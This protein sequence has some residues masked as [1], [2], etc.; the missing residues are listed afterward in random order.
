MDSN[1]CIHPRER[2]KFQNFIHS[3]GF[4]MSYDL[5]IFN[6][7][8]AAPEESFQPLHC[9]LAW[10]MLSE[11]LAHE[12]VVSDADELVWFLPTRTVNIYIGHEDETIQSMGVSMVWGDRSQED[13][14][15]SVLPN[16]TPELAQ[17]QKADLTKIFI[18]LHSLAEKLHAQLYDPQR[19][20]FLKRE[21]IAAMVEGFD[22]DAAV[23][24][25]MDYDQTEDVYLQT[26]DEE[27]E[28]SPRR[29]LT[30][31]PWTILAV[32]F[33]L[34]L[35]GSRLVGEPEVETK[36]NAP[37]MRVL[38]EYQ[39][40]SRRNAVPQAELWVTEDYTIHR[41][42]L[43]HAASEEGLT[44]VVYADGELLGERPAA[45]EKAFRLLDMQ[46]GVTYSVQLK[47]YREE[48][49]RQVSEMVNFRLR[50]AR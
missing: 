26:L 1:D 20:D 22:H 3:R 25:G 34:G 15:A 33:I 35:L 36:N 4:F 6:G 39:P 40:A 7:D 30:F 47:L 19:E 29:A 8:P 48:G 5:E 24:G 2:I 46:T 31:S 23:R 50:A 44:W 17:Q 18:L 27:D 11:M 9:R 42:P 14:D 38:S 21:D 16:A 43:K 13:F 41:S 12:H 45:D 28:I 49:A 10:N 37:Q 32:I